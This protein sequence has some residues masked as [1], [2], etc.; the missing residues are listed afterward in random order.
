MEGESRNAS[1]EAVGWTQS[2]VRGESIPT[3]VTVDVIAFVPTQQ[4]GW[5]R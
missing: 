4:W 3:K 5:G 2:I 1:D